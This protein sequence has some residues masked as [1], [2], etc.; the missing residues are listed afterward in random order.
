LEHQ[1]GVKITEKEL[2]QVVLNKADHHMHTDDS[3]GEL[4]SEKLMRLCR[5]CGVWCGSIT[6]HDTVSGMAQA[7]AAAR[8][9]GF[10]LFPGIEITAE[11]KGREVHILG[12]GVDHK[13]YSVCGY[14]DYIHDAYY[15]R[16]I[17]IVQN[18]EGDSEYNWKVDHAVLHKKSGVI[19]RDGI[20][21]AVLNAGM[22]PAEFY[23]E[24]LADGKKY[25]AKIEKVSVPE[26]IEI[27]RLSGGKSVW[28]HSAFSLRDQDDKHLLSRL[29]KR[30][31]LQGL[32]GLETYYKKYTKEE[33]MNVSRIAEEL[34][35]LRTPGSDF[36]RVSENLPGQYKTHGSK[37]C[38]NEIARIL[39]E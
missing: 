10:R 23:R 19:T 2:Q 16:A 38:P 20:S 3:D 34:G 37:F 29:A 15:A 32:D 12:L 7:I 18:I 35:L 21:R 28:A 4:S 30:F 11:E 6:N 9:Y 13:S 22:L 5:K 24:Y 27:I 1:G 33:T 31:A 8:K 36:H 39:N 17:E 14:S 25:A 26:A